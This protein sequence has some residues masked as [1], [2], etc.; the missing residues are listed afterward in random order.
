MVADD[1]VS[2]RNPRILF[3]LLLIFLCGSLAGAV[4][5]RYGLQPHFY[6]PAPYWSEGGKEISLQKFKKELD[7]TP[8]QADE[9]ETV[10]DDFVKYYQTLQAQMDEVRATGKSRIL[11]ILNAEQKQK[12]EKMLSEL[13]SKQPR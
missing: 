13:Q 3:I 12:F 8:Q 2:W 7:L 10:L 6:K 9:I 1:C 4:A 11:R 5:M